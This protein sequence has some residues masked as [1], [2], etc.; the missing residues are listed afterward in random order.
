MS[1]AQSPSPAAK[2][3]PNTLAAGH[4]N[5][6]SASLAGAVVL[7]SLSLLGLQL[8]FARLLSAVL[9]HH[10]VFAILSSAM[11]GLGLGGLLVHLLASRK[12]S[13]TQTR[14]HF[15]LVVYGMATAGSIPLSVVGIVYL[16]AQPAFY[17]LVSLYFAVVLLP[18]LASGMFFAELYR[19]YARHAKQVYACDLLGAA[20]GGGATIVL[21][22][23]T[24]AIVGSLLLSVIVA[25]G[26]LL[27]VTQ[28]PRAHY[29]KKITMVGGLILGVSATVAA[30]FAYYPPVAS[31]PAA[32]N[33]DKEI[34]D[35][36]NGPWSG[37]IAD[38]RWS[39]FG[40]TQLVIYQDN[41]DHRDIYIDG[42]AGTPMYQFTGN[43]AQPGPA[44]EKLLYYFPGAV[45]F[46]F[47]SAGARNSA[48]IIGPGGGR[49]ILL[50]GAAGFTNIAG[51]EVNP[52]LLQLMREHSDYNG[53]LYS[54]FDH[55]T[56]HQAEGRHF[57][58]RDT[59]Q[60]DLIMMSLPVTNTSRSREGHSL[61]ENFLLTEEALDDY[62][63]H[64]TDHGQLVVIT[65]DELAVV[66]LLRVALEVMADRG[67]DNRTAMQHI[68]VL[69]SFPYPIV[70]ISKRAF[71]P[72]VSRQLFTEIRQRDFSIA[73][74]WVPHWVQPGAGNP[75]L[76]AL[77]Q[78]RINV[79]DMEKYIAGHGHD[80]SS[81]TDNRPFFYHF[82]P[83][84]PAS[85][86]ALSVGSL[87]AALLA[88]AVPMLIGLRPP[89]PEAAERVQR[90]R[91]IRNALLFSILGAGFMLTEISLLQRLTYF[92]GEPVL[93]LAVL[94]SGLL[95]CMG[96]GSL[97]TRWIPEKRSRQALCVTALAVAAV[98]A[99][100]TVALPGW[101]SA[102]IS[103]GLAARIVVALAI[104]VPLGVVLGCPFP[105]ALHMLHQ[106]GHNWTVPWMWA[107]NG[108][109][110][111]TGACAA[112]VVAMHYGLEQVLQA[113]AAA[114]LLLALVALLPSAHNKHYT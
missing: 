18:F 75:M 52:D 55:I 89:A 42:T 49:D 84:L 90:Q 23:L 2:V 98:I 76:Q 60:Y 105:I 111:V 9:Q 108:I 69:G 92:L 74:S 96:V 97:L 32:H 58:Q 24:G 10:Y 16:S 66:R 20:A 29:S 39:A 26:T 22:N 85:L 79:T 5:G 44:V 95:V 94:L 72:Q 45:P 71:T 65:H 68:Y 100:Y 107:L 80:I 101:L 7:V 17:Q 36:L 104:I 83:D 37:S 14:R 30:L 43:F 11:L 1:K 110:S 41:P 13:I 114:Y 47:L 67:I 57:V 59:S 106:S 53:G 35:A 19:L 27:L 73:A 109:F 56:V 40:R 15:R 63:H 38:T 70:T 61:T 99:L 48:L 25:A 4:D 12:R 88:L 6:V 103:G 113:A 78:G 102:W 3:P 28:R 31:L 93:A 34:Y 50:A 112:V 77:A 21:L 62:F 8:T 33:P 86:K 54:G 91:L 87:V 51:A 64:L 46:Q 82:E 81:V